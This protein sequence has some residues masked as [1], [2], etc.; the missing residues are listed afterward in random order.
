MLLTWAVLFFRTVQVR[1]L[2]SES[3]NIRKEN[4]CQSFCLECQML[5]EVSGDDL[6]RRLRTLSCRLKT[7][8][9]P[10]RAHSPISILYSATGSSIFV[11]SSRML[12][13]SI[14]RF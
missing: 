1:R 5:C 2:K 9:I 12:S 6:T 7:Y 11:I 10:S 3:S 4:D 8:R 13:A 14:R